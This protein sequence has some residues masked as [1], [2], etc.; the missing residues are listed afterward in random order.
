MRITQIYG[1]LKDRFGPQNWWPTISENKQFEICVGA[2]LT[3]NTSWKNVEKAIENLHSN[4]LLTQE[5]IKKVNKSKLAKLI[6]SAGYYNQKAKK[7][8]LFADV[9][10]KEPTRSKLL[11]LW[12]I[13]PETADSILCYAYNKPIFVVDAYTKRIFSR[14]GF[15]ENSYEDIQGLVHKDL[16][17]KY[18]NEFHALF[19]VLG[20]DFC[21]KEPLCSECPLGE[22]CNF[23]AT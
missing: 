13:G 2:I 17:S 11:E 12:G 8:K 23:K 18:F 20:K 15:K 4:N 5:A 14:L 10:N 1:I 9:I 19:V 7:L 21:R 6:K 16:N 22:N 3:Q